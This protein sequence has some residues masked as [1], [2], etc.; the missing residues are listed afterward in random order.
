M[1]KNYIVHCVMIYSTITP[2]ELYQIVCLRKTAQVTAF[3]TDFFVQTP[4]VN[5]AHYWGAMPTGMRHAQ[6]RNNPWAQ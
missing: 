6:T 5:H 4:Y 2:I 1:G 3:L